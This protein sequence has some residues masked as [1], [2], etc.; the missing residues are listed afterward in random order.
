MRFR[1]R[2]QTRYAYELPASDSCN[3]LRVCPSDTP[4]QKRLAFRLHVAPPASISEHRDD[5]GNLAHAV[6]IS[7]AH[8]ELTIAVDSIV[9]R[10]DSVPER[11]HQTTFSEYLGD[12]VARTELY[13]QFLR[14]SRY[15]PFSRRLRKF[16]WSARPS[17]GEDLA[18]Y[19]ERMISYVRDQ[20]GYDRGTTHVHSTVDDIL[21]AGGGVC[22]D[23]AHLN[24]GLLRLAGIP[25]RYVSGYVAP[26]VSSD[27]NKPPAELA[28]HAWIEVLLPGVG[29]TGF[30]PTYRS[31]TTPRHI[32][33]AVGRDYSDVPPVRGTYKSSGGDR[34]M[35]IEL[36]VEQIEDGEL[37]LPPDTPDH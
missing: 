20:F 35:T 24:I 11:G 30:D 13:G 15:V 37:R 7:A 18:D 14:E 1:I 33:V 29:W 31:R 9:E 3:E 23:F 22:Q 17:M 10:I 28:T 8:N 26:N 19:V 4:D 5:F 2:Y 32:N 12:D 21:S 25:T 27:P 6:C 16:F 36:R 34:K